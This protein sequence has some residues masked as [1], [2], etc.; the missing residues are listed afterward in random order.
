MMEML[1][2]DGDICEAAREEVAEWTASVYWN[3]VGRILKNVWQKTGFDWFEGVG[4]DDND[5]NTDGNCDCDKDG[6]GNYNNKDNNA[7]VYF[8]F[9]DGKGNEDNINEDVAKEGWDIMDKGGA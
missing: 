3:M 5:D 4:N 6:D 1:D 2:R 7:N 8:V 9:N